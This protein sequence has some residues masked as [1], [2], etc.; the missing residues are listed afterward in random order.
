MVTCP[1]Y[2]T[3]TL[4]VLLTVHL[5]HLY[6]Y[7]CIDVFIQIHICLLHT[8]LQLMANRRIPDSKYVVQP[9]LFSL[10]LEVRFHS[11]I[12]RRI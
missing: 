1:F 12:T 8:L 6:T 4:L 3:H 10:Y 11:V 5:E 9:D 2:T 7:K